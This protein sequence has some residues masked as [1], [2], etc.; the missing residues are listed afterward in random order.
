MVRDRVTDVDVLDK[1]GAIRCKEIEDR[2]RSTI[3]R[4]ACRGRD[5]LREVKFIEEVACSFA[6]AGGVR[7][8]EFVPAWMFGV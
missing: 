5:T 1:A 6:F 2:A 8:G 3:C 7:R 4:V